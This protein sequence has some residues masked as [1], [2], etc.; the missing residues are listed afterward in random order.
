MKKMILNVLF[1]PLRQYKSLRKK[2]RLH[3]LILH[4]NSIG[5]GTF[6]SPKAYIDMH[7][8]GKIKIGENCFIA[9]NAMLLCHTS[10]TKGGPQGAWSKYGGKMEFFDVE[11]GNN[12]LIGANAV[13]Q[14]GVK[15]GN[16]VIV[17]SNCV[18]NKDVPSGYVIG[19]VPYKI[20][21]KTKDLLKAKCENFDEAD[22][23][24]NFSD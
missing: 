20:I 15:I 8:P 16:N 2:L 22:W 6:I 9:R 21:M 19:G 14:P 5:K 4:G 10:V 11:I 18:V 7:P 13:V 23:D 1:V 24:K 3:V 12:V 17:G